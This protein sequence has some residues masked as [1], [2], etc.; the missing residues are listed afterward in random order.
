MEIERKFLVKE[1]PDLQGV[2]YVNMTQGYISHYPVIRIRKESD[3]YFVTMKSSGEICREEYQ[4]QVSENEFNSL[5]DKVEGNV[6]SKTRYFIKLDD[7]LTAELDIFEKE[8]EGLVTVEVEF[9]S[10]EEA[11]SFKAPSWFDI[12]ISKDNRYKN[13]NLSKFGRP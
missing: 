3:K 7:K 2:K 9:N 10:M 11:D 4:M 5:Y 13:N 6:I 1:L 12:D 8:L